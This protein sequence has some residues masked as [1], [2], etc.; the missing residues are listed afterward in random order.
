MFGRRED[1]TGAS[2]LADQVNWPARVA[3]FYA[4]H[5]CRQFVGLEQHVLRILQVFQEVPCAVRPGKNADFIRHTRVD[6]RGL[7][8]MGDEI[9][10]ADPFD[11]EDY[12]G[13]CRL[14]D[15]DRR[16]PC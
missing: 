6:E 9:Q 12:A 8:G 11:D 16:A 14:A 7:G 4:K 2:A 3:F 10:A 5:F 1:Q 13:R 15:L